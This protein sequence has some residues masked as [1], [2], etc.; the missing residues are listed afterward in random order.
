MV[1]SIKIDIYIDDVGGF[2][3]SD[4]VLINNKGDE[5]LT[6][7]PVELEQLIFSHTQ[8]KQSIYTNLIEKTCSIVLQVFLL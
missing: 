6:L 1:K 7:E 5:L 4:T 2:R 3:H 8:F